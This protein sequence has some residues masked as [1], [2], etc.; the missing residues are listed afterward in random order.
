M[1]AGLALAGA[2]GLVLAAAAVADARSRRVPDWLTLPAL[3]GGLVS[4]ALL[5][6]LQGKGGLWQGAA[7]ALLAAAVAAPLAAWGRV[8]WSDVKLLGAV[9]AF[10][11]FPAVAL[12]LVAISVCGTVQAL[13]VLGAARWR[14]SAPPQG[15][16]YGISIAAGS[17]LA[18]VAMIRG[19]WN[20][21]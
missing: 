4:R 3:A 6:G 2:G 15:I 14:S 13:A 10:F 12:A 1:T 18:G 20:E 7:G 8:E 5:H 21:P 16:P 9:G 17:W 19:W 11:S